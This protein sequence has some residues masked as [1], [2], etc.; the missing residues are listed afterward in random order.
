M[1][2]DQLINKKVGKEYNY[3][4]DGCQLKEICS[5]ETVYKCVHCEDVTLCENCFKLGRHIKH[6]FICKYGAEKK[7][8]E[9]EDR[10][11]KKKLDS[12]QGFIRIK[13]KNAR[14]LSNFLASTLPCFFSKNTRWNI[15]ECKKL[16]IKIE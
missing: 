3:Y 6:S 13:L 12:D 2:K 9:C 8:R 15:I 10:K 16:D 1:L 7:W 4:C 14:R 11:M 5:N